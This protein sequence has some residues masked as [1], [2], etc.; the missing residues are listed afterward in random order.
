[1]APLVMKLQVTM[2]ISPTVEVISMSV[3]MPAKLTL[4]VPE[5]VPVVN[6]SKVASAGS[7]VVSTSSKNAAWPVASGA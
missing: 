6:S 2:S 1:M 5:V 4:S 3:M 7:A